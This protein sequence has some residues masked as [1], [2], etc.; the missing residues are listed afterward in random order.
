MSNATQSLA[1]TRITS[2]LDANSFVE[3]GQSVTARNTD[4][5]M[6][7]KKAPSDGVIT[8]YGVI[9]GNLVYVYSQDVS[10]L[11]GTVGEMH[12]K[13]ITRLYDM[14]MKTGAPVIGLI[15]MNKKKIF[16]K[17]GIIL[18]AIIIIILIHT[19]RNMI[20]ISNTQKKL[21]NYINSNNYHM[22]IVSFNEENKQTI[23]ANYYAKDKKQL[24]IIER[25]DNNR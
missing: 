10:V 15:F 23:T 20:I 8:G 6:T 7:E 18:L 24:I 4:F 22:K 11:N 9:D 25:K 16:K 17:L 19:V 13:K 5:N 3:I 14:A 12:A 21:S 1:G 2:L